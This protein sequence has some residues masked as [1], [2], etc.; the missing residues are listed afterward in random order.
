[1]KKVLSPFELLFIIWVIMI[2]KDFWKRTVSFL[3]AF[4]LLFGMVSCRL[5]KEETPSNTDYTDRRLTVEEASVVYSEQQKEAIACSVTSFVGRLVYVCDG[6]I[7]NE[8]QTARVTATVCE[9]ILPI[10][11]KSAIAYEELSRL[12]QA[13]DAFL[14]ELEAA[15]TADSANRI[16]QALCSFYRD[17]LTVLGSGRTGVLLYEMLLFWI[18]Y[19]VA[20]YEERYQKYQYAWYLEDATRYRAH[21]MTLTESVGQET[22]SSVTEALLFCASVL[23]GVL[24]LQS[25]ENAESFLN[26][27]EILML[28]QKQALRFSQIQATDAQWSTVFD[29]L[30]DCFFDTFLL[31]ASLSELQQAELR[32][33]QKADVP[34]NLGTCMQELFQLYRAFTLKTDRNDFKILSSG[35]ALQRAGTFCRILADCEAEFLSLADALEACACAS[36]AKE[37][38]IRNAAEWE[39]YTDFCT[40]TQ[41]LTAEE[42][43]SLIKAFGEA[44]SR[45]GFSGMQEASV[46][47]LYGIFPRATFVFLYNDVN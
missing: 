2:K 16:L 46:A 6:L 26:D 18:D 12:A 24:P 20:F 29:V 21:R 42:Y 13:A 25:E 4:A 44:P 31:P 7:L 19:R 11:E 34:K 3:C 38:A 5:E 9:N 36:E 14:A 47:F 39:S 32:T 35:D 27:A 10:L 28:F 41:A 15:Q 40:Q 45:D 30:S 22:F 1:M 37:Q 33:L 43:L 17:A 8:T 23:S